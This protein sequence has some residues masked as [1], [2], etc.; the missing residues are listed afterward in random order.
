MPYRSVWFALVTMGF[1]WVVA[2][3]LLLR[4]LMVA[5]GGNELTVGLILGTWLLAG[6]AGS[7]AFGRWADRADDPIGLI[8]ALQV[9]LAA[10]IPT[11]LTCGPFLGGPLGLLPGELPGLGPMVL[12]VFGL[13]V[14]AAVLCGGI[15]AT[16]CRLPAASADRPDLPAGRVYAAEAIGSAVGG[17]IFTYLLVSRLS[18]HR[19]ALVVS[20]LNL[21]AALALACRRTSPPSSA[22]L[23]RTVLGSLLAASLVLLFSP[24][25]DALRAAVQRARWSDQHVAFARDSAYGALAVI[26]DAGQHTYY[27][28]GVP[29]ATTPVPDITAVE[30]QAHLPALFHPDPGTVLVVGSGMGGLLSELLKHPVAR[31]D[32]VERD[33][34]LFE[35]ASAVSDT[36][37]TK[38]LAD[39]RVAVHIADGRQFVATTARRYDL[40]LIGLPPPSSLSLNR[41]YTRE[42]FASVRKALRPNGVLALTCPSSTTYLTDD[43]RRLNDSFSEALTSTFAS[44]RAI[45][46]ETVLYLA[47]D[48][49]GI[50]SVDAE[51]LSGRLLGRNIFTRL[52][53]PAHLAYRLDPDEAHRFEALL[54]GELGSANSDLVPVSLFHT[55]GHR[56]AQ[57]SP[58]LRRLLAEREGLMLRDLLIPLAAVALLLAL[59]LRQREEA[60]RIATPLGLAATG[61]AGMA[62]SVVLLMAYQTLYGVLYVQIGLFTA[63]FALGI[64]VGAAAATRTGYRRG[65]H[66]AMVTLEVAILGAAGLIA[67]ALPVLSG[68]HSIGGEVTLVALNG[69]LGALV[70]AQFPI[71]ARI[72]ISRSDRVAAPAGALYAADLAGAWIGAVSV[73]VLLLPSLG[74]VQ[75]CVLVATVKALSLAIIAS[76]NRT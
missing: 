41:Y 22:R 35:A 33:P 37:A 27:V 23:R 74:L 68:T 75:A 14:P 40:V 17:A 54:E 3:V 43:L 38:E 76:T 39:P 28:D 12:L 66:T 47:S 42:F 25:A 5:F 16:G 58:S 50:Q 10:A 49:A 15:F 4:Q 2:Q 31:I 53:T 36:F 48:N 51:A 45:P 56:I 57:V 9:L 70:G 19:I 11:S 13:L 61:F 46:G 64:S 65:P 1:T 8:I 52:I 34:L 67:L 32:Y 63:A 59:V 72:C 24:A 30:E 29:T 55:L 44:V 7:A 62:L 60:W 69:L 21:A 18:A 73:P 6:G 20:A 26:N 71:A